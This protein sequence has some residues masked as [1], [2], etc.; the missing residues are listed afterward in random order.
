MRMIKLV[1]KVKGSHVYTAIFQGFEG[2]TLARSGDFC[3]TY[4]EW[5]TLV[6]LLRYGSCATEN[7]AVVEVEGEEE[8]NKIFSL[9]IP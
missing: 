2:Q 3:Q 4:D 8:I 9:L 6:E 7:L 1:S 5:K